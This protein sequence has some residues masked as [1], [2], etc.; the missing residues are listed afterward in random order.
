MLHK[1]MADL[2]LSER[3]IDVYLELQKLGRATPARLSQATGINRTTVYSIAKTLLK[4][5][6]AEGDLGR[7]TLELTAPPP[8][9]L[10]I[11]LDKNLQELNRKRRIADQAIAELKLLPHSRAL[12][13]PRIRFVEQHEIADFLRAR[14]DEW[15]ESVKNATGTWWGFQDTTFV[16]S[17][18]S[19]V[20]EWFKRKSSRGL[21]VK[22]LSNNTS[23]EKQMARGSATQREVR[24]W[25][26]IKFTSSLWVVGEYVIVLY[27]RDEPYHLIEIKNKELARNLELVFQN[28]WVELERKRSRA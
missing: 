24:F 13:V 7:K 27:T 3:E 11:L 25:K 1:Q 5:G 20:Q 28:L 12:E 15:N 16:S 23:A 18:G 19:W 4:K 17:Y 2:G 10:A 6:L 14:L 9:N 22:L 21:H 26:D 8:E